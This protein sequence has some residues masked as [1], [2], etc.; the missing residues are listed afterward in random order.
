MVVMRFQ[1]TAGFNKKMEAIS[2]I[3]TSY[4]CDFRVISVNGVVDH[5]IR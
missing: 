3:P 4:N 2:K 5:H 1:Y